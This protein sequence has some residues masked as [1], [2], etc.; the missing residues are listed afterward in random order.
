LLWSKK[1]RERVNIKEIWGEVLRNK[2]K[3][4]KK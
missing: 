3:I 1:E 2:K 4:V